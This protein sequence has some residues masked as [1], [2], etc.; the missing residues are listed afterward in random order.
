MVLHTCSSRLLF[1]PPLSRQADDEP[2]RAE[3]AYRVEFRCLA[4]EAGGLEAAAAA[5]PPTPQPRAPAILQKKVA[6]PSPPHT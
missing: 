6:P 3:A 5:S 1:T 4:Q 2:L